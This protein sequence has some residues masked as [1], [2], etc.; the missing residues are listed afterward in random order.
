MA[1]ISIALIGLFNIA[2]SLVAGALGQHY[3]MKMI[4]AVMYASRAVMIVIYLLAP[5]TPLTFYI[6]AAAL[7]FTHD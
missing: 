7:G 1:G 5:P 4:L 6:F 2:G 3:R